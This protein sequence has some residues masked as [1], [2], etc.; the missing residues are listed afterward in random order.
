MAY[1]GLMRKRRLNKP[2]PIDLPPVLDG[3]SFAERRDKA[4]RLRQEK[5]DK[6]AREQERLL[7][8]RNTKLRLGHNNAKPILQKK[9]N[10]QTQKEE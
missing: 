8:E 6:Q 4:I 10:A 3:L 5:V 2:K 9:S 1:L 7:L